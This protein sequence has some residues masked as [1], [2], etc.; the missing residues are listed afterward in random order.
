MFVDVHCHLNSGAFDNDRD[1]V[2]K[3]AEKIGMIIIDSGTCMKDNRKSLN[4]SRKYRIVKSSFGLYPIHAVRLNENELSREIEFIEKSKN[5][6]IAVGEIGMDGLE[7]RDIDE[8]KKIFERMLAL[9]EKI[10][11]PVVVHS[12]KAERECIEIME[13]FKIRNVDMHCFTG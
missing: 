7:S 6:I 9:A 8:Q 13:S 2:I 3:R 12:R 11:K 4:L 1:E 5:G 10:R